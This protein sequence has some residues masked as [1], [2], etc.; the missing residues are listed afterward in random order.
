VASGWRPPAFSPV[1]AIED[2]QRRGV[3]TSRQSAAELL[4][5]VLVLA[6]MWHRQGEEVHALVPPSERRR[7]VVEAV[8]QLVTDCPP[9]S[10]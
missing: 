10:E 9:A 2:A 4:A 1:T 8:R 6:Y 5:L 7:V 3:V